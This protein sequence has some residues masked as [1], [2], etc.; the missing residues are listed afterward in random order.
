MQLRGPLV[1][2][3]RWWYHTLLK[4]T[5]RSFSLLPSPRASGR[6]VALAYLQVQALAVEASRQKRTSGPGRSQKR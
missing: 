3:D 2:P 1:G 5:V 4:G 6:T